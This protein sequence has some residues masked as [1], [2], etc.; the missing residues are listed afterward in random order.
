MKWGVRELSKKLGSLR[1]RL[2]VKTVF[3]LTKAHDEDL[4]E[5]TRE[6]VKWLLCKERNTPYIVYASTILLSAI[7]HSG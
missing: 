1:L 5:Y 4:V 2:N 6:V 3:I 7:A